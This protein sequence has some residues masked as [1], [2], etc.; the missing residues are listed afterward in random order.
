MQIKAYSILSTAQY[1]I[2]PVIAFYEIYENSP[3]RA[4]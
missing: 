4:P 2:V 3:V 1:I